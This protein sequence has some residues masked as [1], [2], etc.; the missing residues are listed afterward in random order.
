MILKDEDKEE[1]KINIKLFDLIKKNKWPEFIEILTQNKE[2]KVNIR[3]S[4]NNYLISYAIIANNLPAVEL[5][6]KRNAKLDIITDDNKTLLYLPIKYNYINLI[7]LILTLDKNNVGEPLVNLQ[8]NSIN[9]NISLHYAI[10]TNNLELVILLQNNINVTYVD[11]LGNNALMLA[12]NNKNINIIKNLINNTNINVINNENNSCLHL[13]CLNNDY[14]ATKILLFNKINVNLLN[15]TY[16]YPAIFYS[17]FNKNLDIVKL[18]LKYN[19]NI[20]QQDYLG[21]SLMHY[22]IQEDLDL[23]LLIKIKNI[24][25]NLYNL[26]N[27]LPVILFLENLENL[28]NSNLNTLNTF[29][30][31]S[32]LNFQSDIGESCLFIL[33]KLNIWKKYKKI[34][35]LKKLNCLIKNKQNKSLISYVL[36]EDKDEFI[37]MIT[38]SY[39]N[40]ILNSKNVVWKDKDDNKIRE[41]LS[42]LSKNLS[43][44]SKNLSN[45]NKN[46]N[47]KIIKSKIVSLI[48]N[49]NIYNNFCVHATYPIKKS[50]MCINITQEEEIKM[51][52]FTGATLDVLFGLIYILT[53]F[54]NTCTTVNNIINKEKEESK[55]KEEESKES[56]N[57]NLNFELLWNGDILSLPESFITYFNSCTQNDKKLFTIVPL[58]I[59][60]DKGSHANYLIYDKKLKTVERFEPHGQSVPVGFDYNY[61]KLDRA[62]SLLFL[63]INK[64]IRYVSPVEY[65]PKIGFQQLGILEQN[66][67]IG[68]PGGF[69]AIWTIWYVE[70]RLT[71]I[72]IKNDYLVGQLLKT[73][74]INNISF[75]NLV[76]NYSKNITE[77]RDKI[78]NNANL[79]INMWINDQY[80]DEQYAKIIFEINNMLLN[81]I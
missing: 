22:F 47:L 26:N 75:Q 58:A 16:E 9:N 60:L 13:S 42:N 61:L 10:E 37:D 80:N 19:Y 59:I 1:I 45:L 71:Y 31:N 43:N 77:I 29:L 63:D 65:M 12:I 25:Y 15:K 18:I 52:T 57:N 33:V 66:S 23:E 72:D 39:Y 14:E 6:I 49:L 24:N 20:N 40:V 35:V 76:R 81:L 27:K 79:D 48:N 38:E 36:K 56:K 30:L 32:N 44:L 64:K 53:K 28:S 69:C 8:D 74:K 34:L 2:I 21:N 4:N 55:S 3:D 68:D 54:N 11:N 67:K 17:V 78:L 73:I 41:N 51:A 46:N 5:L 7:K 70:Q 50:K 62:L